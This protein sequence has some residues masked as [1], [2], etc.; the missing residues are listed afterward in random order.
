MRVYFALK[1]RLTKRCSL[2]SNRH[3]CLSSKALLK[4][5][6]S[7]NPIPPN[8]LGWQRESQLFQCI[9]LPLLFDPHQNRAINPW[10]SWINP[11][12]NLYTPI[13]YVGIAWITDLSNTSL[14]ALDRSFSFHPCPFFQIRSLMHAKT[15]FF[16]L[17]II[18]GN[19][20]YF[21][22]RSTSLTPKISIISCLWWK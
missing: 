13:K 12:E 4:T 2:V 17:P 21:S 16:D 3:N 20:R 9:V 15:A 11:A 1:T 14:P 19:P 5:P 18:V 10:I 8:H 22:W 6:K 7:R